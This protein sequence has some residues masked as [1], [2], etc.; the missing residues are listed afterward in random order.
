[1][2]PTEHDVAYISHN[3]IVQD[4][5]LYMMVFDNGALIFG[6]YSNLL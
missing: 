5:D 4:V 2:K 6:P 3:L 1:M